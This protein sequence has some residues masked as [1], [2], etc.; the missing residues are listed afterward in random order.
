LSFFSTSLQKD[1]SEKRTYSRCSPYEP[2]KEWRLFGAVFHTATPP[3]PSQHFRG[4][5]SFFSYVCRATPPSSPSMRPPPELAYNSLS[6]PSPCQTRPSVPPPPILLPSGGS[7][8]FAEQKRC[9]RGSLARF[10][11]L[12]PGRPLFLSRKYSA[13]DRLP[14]PRGFNSSFHSFLP[15]PSAPLPEEEILSLIRAPSCKSPLYVLSPRSSV[16][17]DGVRKSPASS[18][19]QTPGHCTASPPL[20]SSPTPFSWVF[21]KIKP[22]SFSL[23]PFLAP[24]L[25][26]FLSVSSCKVE[27][28]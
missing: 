14:P 1:L 11:L 4:T 18:R 5:F 9:R 10:P 23:A 25:S 22:V 15:S 27:K 24:G 13:Y 12:A 19:L 20:P 21:F 6:F 28:S 8:F 26:F 17:E 16:P 7:F 2:P 3:L